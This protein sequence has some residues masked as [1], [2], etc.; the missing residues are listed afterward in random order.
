MD[1]DA[2]VPAGPPAKATFV[3]LAGLLTALLSATL[4]GVAFV[5]T[6]PP[7]SEADRV[8]IQ[9]YVARRTG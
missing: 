6:K 1:D 7:V 4:I 9:R 5:S 3:D 8:L 2:S